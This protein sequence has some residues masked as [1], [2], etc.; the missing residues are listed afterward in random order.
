LKQ[1]SKTEEEEQDDEEGLEEDIIDNL[2]EQ[3]KEFKVARLSE[4]V[5]VDI[6]N[7]IMVLKDEF[8]TELPPDIV[9]RLVVRP[10]DLEQNVV[11]QI[12]VFK[13]AAL[14]ILE[15]PFLPH[16]PILLSFFTNI[17]RVM[18]FSRT[19]WPTW[20]SRTS[21]SWIQTCRQPY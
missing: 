12:K 10:E 7:L 13:E 18:V 6:I 19:K 14:R 8:F 2:E 1:E 15:V 16:R 4:K 9:E 21:S 5:T 17:S 3:T 11:E 20:T